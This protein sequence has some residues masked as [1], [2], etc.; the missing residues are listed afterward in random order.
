MRDRGCIKEGEVTSVGRAG[1]LAVAALRKHR[2]GT[3]GR[4]KEAG[5]ESGNQDGGVLCYPD[6]WSHGSDNHA[7]RK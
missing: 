1:L 7:I 6:P 5:A 2:D 4:G 3:D